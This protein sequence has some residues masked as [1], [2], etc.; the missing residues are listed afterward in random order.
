MIIHLFQAINRSFYI[1]SLHFHLNTRYSYSWNKPS[2]PC[3]WPAQ[4]AH[5]IIK[6]SRLDKQVLHWHTDRGVPYL[7]VSLVSSI[8]KTC[9]IRMGQALNERC[10][11]LIIIAFTYNYPLQGIMNGN[12]C[13]TVYSV[14]CLPGLRRVACA[15]S[16]RRREEDV[17]WR[18]ET[19][20]ELKTKR[21]WYSSQ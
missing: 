9:N 5:V 1:D 20:I 17:F 10:E 18:F 21:W 11:I 7:H 14:V 12:F 19:W 3:D 15:L 16:C 6:L 8:V 2:Q 4:A 13:A